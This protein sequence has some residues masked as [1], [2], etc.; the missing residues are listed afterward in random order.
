ML[1]KKAFLLLELLI[2]FAIFSIF[3]LF[4]LNFLN[5]NN[6]IKFFAKLRSDCISDL[7]NKLYIGDGDYHKIILDKNGTY[8]DFVIVK[9]QIKYLNREYTVMLVGKNYA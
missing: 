1:S 2:A 7:S 8:F 6:K 9:N 3:S 4:F 5:L